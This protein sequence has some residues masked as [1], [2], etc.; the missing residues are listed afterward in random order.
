MGSCERRIRCD[1]S[2]PNAVREVGEFWVKGRCLGDLCHQRRKLALGSGSIEFRSIVRQGDGVLGVN[3]K[4][5]VEFLAR[6]GR[7]ILG[8]PILGDRLREQALNEGGV[9][10]DVHE[11]W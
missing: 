10:R 6:H 3:E 1:R 5:V 7:G 9:G 8:Q 11:R 2:G 4:P